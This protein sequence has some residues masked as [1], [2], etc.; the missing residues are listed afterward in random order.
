MVYIMFVFLLVVN[1]H[2]GKGRISLAHV[3]YALSYKN[4]DSYSFFST[5]PSILYD[6]RFLKVNS[7]IHFSRIIIYADI[8]SWIWDKEL[9][10]NVLGEG[11]IRT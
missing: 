1:R 2:L 9:Y 8:Q 3:T 6:I 5:C 11:S 4:K 10:S 7:Q